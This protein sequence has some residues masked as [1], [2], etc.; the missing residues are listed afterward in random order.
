MRYTRRERQI[1]KLIAKGFTNKQIAEANSTSVQT[2]KNQI[3]LM[4]IRA[5]VHTRTHLLVKALKTGD[6]NIKRSTKQPHVN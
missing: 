2:V 6:I 1:L 3:R 4:M 5:D